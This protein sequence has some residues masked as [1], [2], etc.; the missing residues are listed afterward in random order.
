MIVH[1]QKEENRILVCPNEGCSYKTP[2]KI[3]LDVH[4]KHHHSEHL[5]RDQCDLC[6]KKFLNKT[7]LKLHKETHSKVKQHICEKCGKGFTHEVG[8]RAHWATVPNCD[9]MNSTSKEWK[10]DQCEDKFSKIASYLAHY[11]VTHKGT[12][13]NLV[14]VIELHHCDQC[15][16]AFA[17]IGGLNNHK[18]FV[19]QGIKHRTQR[20]KEACPYCGKL[21]NRSTALREHI[22]SKHENDTPYE[23][24]ECPKA[25]GTETFLR[26]HIRQ[27]HRKIKCEVCGKEVCNNFW[28]K[29]HM[30]K[31]HG[32]VGENSHQCDLCSAVFDTMD[33]K[34][35]HAASSY[36]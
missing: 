2:V 22:K 24:T 11:R 8:L 20:A 9:L 30:A 19:H 23:C 25:F 21:V 17:S 31:V 32:V 35:K 26:L 14:G 13:M 36:A 4:I 7:L 29:R 12:P 27:A 3:N 1:R 6:G 34:S 33:A 16:E 18:K 28:Y 15:S 5:H 10:C